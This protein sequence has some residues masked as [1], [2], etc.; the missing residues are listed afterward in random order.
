MKTEYLQT[1][2]DIALFVKRKDI[3]AL[4][5]SVIYERVCKRGFEGH[6]IKY[7]KKV[8]QKI[9]NVSWYMLRTPQ[10]LQTNK[11]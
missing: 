8:D 5:K 1:K 10:Y 6:T 7:L 3:V 2:W 4:I 11:T 9:K